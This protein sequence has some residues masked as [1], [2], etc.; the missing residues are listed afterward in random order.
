V[1]RKIGEYMIYAGKLTHQM[2]IQRQFITQDEELNSISA[3]VDWRTVWCEP[4]SHQGKE[5]YKLQNVNSEI[6]EAFRIRYMANITQHHRIKFKN[7]Y[8][9]IIDVDNVGQKNIELILSCKA[10]V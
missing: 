10:V 5:Y 8:Y 3:W 7:K 9:E 2:T 4:M 6:E 1:A